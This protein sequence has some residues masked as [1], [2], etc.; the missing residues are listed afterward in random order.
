MESDVCIVRKYWDSPMVCAN[1]AAP[2]TNAPIASSARVARPNM[3]NLD[4]VL[5]FEEEAC[6][7]DSLLANQMAA[8]SSSNAPSGTMSTCHTKPEM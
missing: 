3:P 7:V 2:A 5:L 8:P 1:T 6:L 4:G